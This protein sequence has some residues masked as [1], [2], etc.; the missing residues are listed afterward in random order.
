MNTQAGIYSLR[1]SVWFKNYA[2]N[3]VDKDFTII[4]EENNCVAPIIITPSA[5][6]GNE[7]FIVGRTAVTTGAFADFTA[8]S[9]FCFVSG[10][11]YTVTPALIF[12][13]DA[14]IEFDSVLRSFT[15][16][17]DNIALVGDYDVRVT[18]L[19]PNGADTGSGWNWTASI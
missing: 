1:V 9:T 18:A 5:A 13:D 16:Q 3:V 12:P 6:I 17:T 10:Y 7:T 15:I 4:I 2:T 8:S 14:T 11:M 19:T